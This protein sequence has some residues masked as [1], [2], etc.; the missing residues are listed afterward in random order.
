MEPQTAAPR[1]W[2]KEFQ[3][4]LL[5]PVLERGTELQKL[6][7]EFVATAKQF[8]EVIIRER[9]LPYHQKTIK[10]LRGKG[11]AGGEKYQVA[12]IF[13]KF[14]VNKD[15]SLYPSDR[16]AMKVAG[17]SIDPSFFLSVAHGEGVFAYIPTLS[18]V[19][20][21]LK[22]LTALVSCGMILGLSFPLLALIDWRGYR[23]IA[24]SALPISEDTIVYGSCDGGNSVHK[25]SEVLITTRPTTRHLTLITVCLR[26][27]FNRK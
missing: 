17:T 7:D 11:L 22:G 12:N 8:G 14:A 6:C 1:N 20:H 16:F 24:T 21:E 15:G 5:R 10:P 27:S 3:E 2:T 26:V 9:N 19:G 25:K 4:I 18:P 23:L 13:F